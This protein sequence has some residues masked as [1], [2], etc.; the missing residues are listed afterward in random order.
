MTICEFESNIGEPRATDSQ[1]EAGA[2]L[3][4]MGLHFLTDYAL[5][6]CEEWAA[7]LLGHPSQAFLNFVSTPRLL[8]AG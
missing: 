4:L 5:E 1:R 8:T 6:N 7:T 3:D 2:F